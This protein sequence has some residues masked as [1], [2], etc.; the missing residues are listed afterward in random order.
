M[1]TLSLTIPLR[2]AFLWPLQDFVWMR[3]LFL[4]EAMGS[5]L[6][7]VLF[8]TWHFLAD[9]NSAL[10]WLFLI[11]SP[12]FRGRWASNSCWFTKS[13]CCDFAQVVIDIFLVPYVYLSIRVSIAM[14][15]QYGHNSEPPQELLCVRGLMYSRCWRGESSR[16]CFSSWE[17]VLGFWGGTAWQGGLRTIA[18][19]SSTV[20]EGRWAQLSSPLL[21]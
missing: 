18:C 11:Y 5:L 7:P 9:T 19:A 15:F 20:L 3:N 13:T 10:K 1:N 8:H 21:I 12:F 16:G 17:V 2:S 14:Y 4:Q 6:S